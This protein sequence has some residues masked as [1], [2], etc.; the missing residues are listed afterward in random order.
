MQSYKQY[1]AN[2]KHVMRY[3]EKRGC[4]VFIVMRRN[5]TVKRN[6]RL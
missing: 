6:R 3:K 4:V 5:L 1:K 2:C